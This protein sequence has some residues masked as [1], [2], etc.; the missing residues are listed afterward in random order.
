M[1]DSI[2]GAA[3]AGIA[4]V[5]PTAFCR[6]SAELAQN[7]WCSRRCARAGNRTLNLG[8]KSLLAC[9]VRECQGVPGNAKRS[10]THDATALGSVRECQGVSA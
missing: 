1:G 9:S 3:N 7:C 4:S 6:P 2:P 8:I 5:V 10:Q